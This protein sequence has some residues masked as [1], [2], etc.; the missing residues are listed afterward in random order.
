M[1]DYWLT[2]HD[3]LAHLVGVV[4]FALMGVSMLYSLRKRKWLLAQGRM[5]RWLSLHHWAGFLGGVMALSHS[6]GNM[7][8]LGIPLVAMLLLVLGSSGLYFLEKRHR[9]PL[10]QAAATLASE[11]SERAKLDAEYRDLYAKGMVATPQG[12]ELYNRLMAQHQRVV[13]VENEVARLQEQA[14]R[15][16]WWRTIHNVSTMML[17]GVVIVHIWS[18][19]FFSG[20]GV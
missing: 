17:L 19:M 8:A 2:D 1:T 20:V 16:C 18:K 14:P 6:L 15:W 13:D 11:R 10:L 7:D 5:A 12:A 9:A 3:R 4:G